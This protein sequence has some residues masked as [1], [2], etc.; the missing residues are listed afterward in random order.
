MFED[1]IQQIFWIEMINI[2]Y[3]YTYMNHI[4]Y[5]YRNYKLK[6]DIFNFNFQQIIKLNIY[7]FII[8]YKLNFF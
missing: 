3:F 1:R 4:K 6:Q 7:I 2:K 5:L 8:L